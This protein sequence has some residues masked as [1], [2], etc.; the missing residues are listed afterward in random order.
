MD[1]VVK[2]SKISG[3]GVFANKDF[4]MGEIVL[5]WHPKFLKE[6][7]VANYFDQKEYLNIDNGKTF[8]MMEPERNINHSCDPNTK[9]NTEKYCDIAIKNIKKG[10]EITS[11]YSG[12]SNP[13]FICNCGSKN[14]KGFFTN[15][16][17]F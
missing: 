10:E 3:K 13:D 1:I 11:D 12:T 8:L 14:C 15:K 4:K 16:N 9:A 6:E 2:K 5:N 7:E 17:S